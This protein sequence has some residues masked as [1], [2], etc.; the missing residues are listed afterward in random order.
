MK[1]MVLVVTIECE[2][3]ACPIVIGEAI[4]DGLSMLEESLADA[5]SEIETIAFE[6]A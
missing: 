6:E 4:V 5:D 2:D 1:T 3:K